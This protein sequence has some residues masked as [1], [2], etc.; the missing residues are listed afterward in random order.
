MRFDWNHTYSW[1]IRYKD[2]R[3]EK[4][5][6]GRTGHLHRTPVHRHTNIKKGA[7]FLTVASHATGLYVRFKRGLP[8]NFREIIV[9]RC[10]RNPI[11][12]LRLYDKG[13]QIQVY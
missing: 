7:G 11:N 3:G 9:F 4:V 5:F 12:S 6:R 1:C 2:N 10:R 13:T 8:S